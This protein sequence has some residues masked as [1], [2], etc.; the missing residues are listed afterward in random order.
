MAADANI[1]IAF[2]DLKVNKMVL[3]NLGNVFAKNNEQAMLQDFLRLATLDQANY[4]IAK[5]AGT[6]VV[7]YMAGST[8]TLKYPVHLLEDRDNIAKG[9]DS[10]SYPYNNDREVMYKLVKAGINY[11][12]KGLYPA[13]NPMFDLTDNLFDCFALLS[14]YQGRY[15]GSTQAGS[16][17]NFKRPTSIFFV[18]NNGEKIVATNWLDANSNTS[19][20]LNN[21]TVRLD[22]PVISMLGDLVNNG[23]LA[24]SGEIVFNGVVLN[25]ILK[26]QGKDCMSED[27]FKTLN[28]FLND[29][30]G[31]FLNDIYN[32]FNSRLVVTEDNWEFVATKIKRYQ[33][34]WKVYM[35]GKLFPINI[36][37]TFNTTL[38]NKESFKQFYKKPLFY[39]FEKKWVDKKAL[40]DELNGTLEG[41]RESSLIT[42]KY[43]RGVNTSKYKKINTD[44][45]EASPQAPKP[46]EKSQ[47]SK[48]Q[49]EA[50]A[51]F[52]KR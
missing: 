21:N 39:I 24:K 52:K 50:L 44:D 16:F 38:L 31:F 29:D 6:Y 30:K 13:I 35:S 23:N 10:W 46:L 18:I 27:D 1:I 17:Y 40:L 32:F 43:L 8:T 51:R 3:C 7:D 47:M 45:I 37:E 41:L 9:K 5:M 2:C 49:L 33:E 4:N 12:E 11:A 42:A 36:Y 48:A 19:S 34:L 20:V 15:N 22:L 26:A 14:K 28:K 25:S